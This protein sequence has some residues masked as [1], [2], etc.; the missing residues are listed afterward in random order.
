MHGFPIIGGHHLN[1]VPGTTVQ[2]CS[3]WS[4]ADAF[5][6]ADAE[7]RIDFNTPERWMIFVRHPK[8]AG[9]NRTVFDAGWGARTPGAAVGCDRKYSRPLLARRLAVAF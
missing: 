4:F 9:F 5:L 2:K 6:T 8:H 1:C 7:I 3:V